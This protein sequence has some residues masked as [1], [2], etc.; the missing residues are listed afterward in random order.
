M[1]NFNTGW[2]WNAG[3]LHRGFFWNGAIFRLIINVHETIG[4]SEELTALLAN[5]AVKDEK[6]KLLEAIANA[7]FVEGTDTFKLQEDEKIQIETLFEVADKFKM[8]DEL[9]ELL[10]QAAVTDNFNLIEKVKEI[11]AYMEQ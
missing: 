8:T 3:A 2:R 6:L 11:N 9:T 10:V 4:L 1:A 7:A 5:L